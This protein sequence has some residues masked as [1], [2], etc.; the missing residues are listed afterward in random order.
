[1]KTCGYKWL[2]GKGH[3]HKCIVKGTPGHVG[4]HRCGCGQTRLSGN[5]KGEPKWQ[6]PVRPRSGRARIR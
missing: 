5:E 1:M 4:P 6:Q 2:S 3:G